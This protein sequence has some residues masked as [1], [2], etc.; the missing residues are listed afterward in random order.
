MDAEVFAKINKNRKKMKMV[1][2]VLWI[3]FCS[4]SIMCMANRFREIQFSFGI[5]IAI[6]I[7]DGYTTIK[8]TYIAIPHLRLMHFY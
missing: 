2:S 4:N 6:S 5:S 7:D 8:H 3:R 1:A